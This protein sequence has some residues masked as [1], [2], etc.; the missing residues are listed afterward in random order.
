MRFRLLCIARVLCIASALGLMLG[1]Q[2]A[3]A[4]AA[5]SEADDP[6][7]ASSRTSST[8]VR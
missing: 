3:P 6:W 8:I 1:A 2:V 4:P 5:T 7:P